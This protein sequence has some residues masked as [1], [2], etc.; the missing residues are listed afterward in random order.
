MLKTRGQSIPEIH[1]MVSVLERAVS[2]MEALTANPMLENVTWTRSRQE[3]LNWFYSRSEQDFSFIGICIL[4]DLDPARALDDL[5][6]KIAALKAAEKL[7][8]NPGSRPVLFGGWVKNNKAKDKEICKLYIDGCSKK[9][10]GVKFGISE[11]RI[12]QIIRDG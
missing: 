9:Y 4:V 7:T 10:L 2:D 12:S 8:P 11:T 6:G 1:L 5:A 3:L